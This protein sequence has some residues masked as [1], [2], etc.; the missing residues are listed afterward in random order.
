[1]KKTDKYKDGEEIKE[2]FC[3]VCLAV[4]LTML[5]SGGI[6]G[7]KLGSNKKKKKIYKWTG[8]I[9]FLLALGLFIYYIIN[10][11]NCKSCII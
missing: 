3:P 11:K 1:M 5:A 7:S 8:I 10:R 2:D 4:P 9:C 6:A